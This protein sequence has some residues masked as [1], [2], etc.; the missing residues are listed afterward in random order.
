VDGQN[1]LSKLWQQHL[2]KL[3]SV[4]LEVAEAIIKHYPTPKSLFEVGIQ[5]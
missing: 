5:L 1:G 2:I 4:T 3:P